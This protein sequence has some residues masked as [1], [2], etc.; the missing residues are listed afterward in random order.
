MAILDQKLIT[1][2]T[3]VKTSLLG[4]V[5][6]YLTTSG[7]QGKETNITKDRGLECRFLDPSG[8]DLFYTLAEA[9][10]FTFLPKDSKEKEKVLNEVVQGIDSYLNAIP[11]HT[12]AEIKEAIQFLNIG[13]VRWYVFGSSSD[14]E[15]TNRETLIK[16][17]NQWKVSSI[18][19]LR[20]IFFLLQSMVTIGYFD[21]SVSWKH[22]GYPGPE[23][24]LGLRHG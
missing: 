9:L 13:V 11:P 4:A 8:Q 23:H 10:L 22:I 2:R 16:T 14:W 24:A 3:V 6:L 19:L 7:C 20:S 18:G 15:Q 21:T 5:F 1:R 12:Q 17:L